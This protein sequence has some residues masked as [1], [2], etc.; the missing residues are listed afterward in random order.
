MRIVF[1]FIF[2]LIIS[3]VLGQDTYKGLVVDKTT[4][5]PV[6]FVNIGVVGK[7]MGTVS[8]EKGLFYLY[9]NDN[10]ILS[11][12]IVQ[13][14]SLGYQTIEMSVSNAKYILHEHSKIEMRSE[15][16]LLD[17]VVVSNTLLVPII[18]PVGYRS[19]D[20][21]NFGYW[22]DNKALG[23]EL[24]TRIEV[25]NQK[26]KLSSLEFEILENLSDSLLL[27]VNVYDIGD[28]DG[29]P[30]QNLNKSNKNILY[31]LKKHEVIV[32]IDLEPYNILVNS[33]FYIS[34][35]LVKR[36]NNK[37][38]GLVLAAADKN[39]EHVKRTNKKPIGLGMTIPEKSKG[40]YRRYS[41]QGKWIKVSNINMAFYLET[42]QLVSKDK[43]K[44]IEGKQKK[45]REKRRIVSGFTI[46][47]GKMVS[48]VAVYNKRT[49]EVTSS[50]HSGRYTI[51]AVKNDIL[52]FSKNRYKK[53]LVEIGKQQFANAILQLE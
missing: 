51:H 29:G 13:F 35:E 6:P 30:N 45:D 38:V 37:P 50:D 8:D 46:S 53:V 1:Q 52:I 7:G 39:D 43:A 18:K 10:K 24:A 34:L 22:K 17:E 16:V 28:N 4:K 42:K 33:S 41:S 21:N 47:G 44:K 36:Y 19:T 11:T 14:S 32:K 27:R 15:N 20:N 25:N 40:T 49:K 31:T 48:N 26:R 23:G 3:S 2:L 9:F 5:Q 12:D